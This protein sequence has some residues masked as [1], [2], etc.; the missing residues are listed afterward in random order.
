MARVDKMAASRD[1][2]VS[3]HGL[4]ALELAFPCVTCSF[5]VIILLLCFCCCPLL[6]YRL[7]N[8]IG[9]DYLALL[10]SMLGLVVFGVV[11]EVLLVARRRGRLACCGR[12][13]EAPRSFSDH[14]GTTHHKPAVKAP[15]CGV[16]APSPRGPPP[17]YD[18]VS[19]NHPATSQL[20][21]KTSLQPSVEG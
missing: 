6:L 14:H 19:V 5:V 9:Y 20:D 10:Y 2:V 3:W 12:R 7:R 15:L 21:V 8:E 11:G 16:H 1:S 4:G 13:E 17:A 18:S